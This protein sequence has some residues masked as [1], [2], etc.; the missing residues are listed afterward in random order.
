[1]GVSCFL[2][3]ALASC[4]PPG[5]ARL[6]EVLYDAEGGDTGYEFV[7]LYN[8]AAVSV[9]LLGLR[10]EAG[11]G[12]GPG[13]WTARWTG[14]PGDSIPARGR[15]VIGGALVDP[16]PDAVAT[17]DLQNGPDA[18]RLAWPDGTTEVL[19]Y[20]AL[21]YAEYFCGAPAPDVSAGQSLARVP[22]DA[23]LGSNALDFRAAA[24]SPGRA[25]QVAFDAALVRGSLAL[26][27]EQPAAFAGAR[28]SGVAVNLGAAPLAAGAVSIACASVAGTLA[29]S[30]L[31]V[32]LA[33]AE[34]VGFALEL[35]GMPAGRQAL[36]ARV[37]LAGDE[38]GANDA[39]TLNARF[40]PG[41]LEIT[42]IQ[43]HPRG[44]EGEWVEVRSRAGATLD[45]AGFT[46]S[47]RGA[48]RG[49]STGGAA[50]LAP[51]S[52]AVLAQDRS[53]LLARFP[54]LDPERVV[55]IAPWSALNNSDD[56]SGFADAVVLR[57]TDGTRCDRVDYSARG[58][59]DGV[60]IERY[61][62]GWGTSG[63]P[64]GTPLR[65]PLEPAPIAGRIE[66]TPRR[67]PA[68]AGPLRVA[69]AL[70]WPRAR[71]TVEVYDLAGRRV[72]R[73][74][75]QSVVP[76]RA[77]RALPITALPPGVYRVVVRAQAESG[78]ETLIDARAVRVDGSVR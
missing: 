70:P 47:D 64:A 16:P 30:T 32:A 43:F 26:E 36:V 49:V 51:E 58:V 11:D 52:L 8:P 29:E 54:A 40:G 3:L 12:A 75:P 41:P 21:V 23:D 61:P 42:E 28:L 33:P 7:E 62:Y 35:P 4:V 6:N 76:G 60:P 19:G 65:P 39:D 66:I 9:A 69:W 15:F 22:D 5:H 2:A 59:P 56:A 72:A 44:G 55:A 73:L 57:E 14:G 27:P 13:R 71:V 46:L 17:L 31:A 63:D 74:A 38:R 50:P 37:T 25:N 34:S 18:V 53:A 68:G 67:L 24:P 77:E 48:A 45:L 10:I 78:N 20:G 1:M